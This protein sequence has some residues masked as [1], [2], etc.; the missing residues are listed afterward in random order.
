MAEQDDLIGTV[1]LAEADFDKF[2]ACGGQILTHVIGPDG[3]FAVSPVDNHSELDLAGTAEREECVHGRADGPPGVEDI[4]DE[5]DSGAGEVPGNDG[6]LDRGPGYAQFQVVSEHC[7][8][9]F[10][11]RY[12]CA[13]EL[14]DQR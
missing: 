13:L 1:D 14:A 12:R 6:G 7:D 5:D 11:D 4:I 10:A 2:V 8:V 9:E 3:K